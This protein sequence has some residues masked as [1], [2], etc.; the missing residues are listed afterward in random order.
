MAC[1]CGPQGG[2]FENS[3]NYSSPAHGGWGVVKAGHLVPES[4]QLFVSPAACGRHGALAARIEGRK[5]RVS[6]LFLSEEEL[7]SGRYEDAIIEGVA[8]L[9]KHL[10]KLKRKPRALMIFVSCIDDLLGTDHEAILDELYQVHTGVKFIF[11]HMNPTSTDSSVPP[12]VNIQ[13][14]NYTLLD[15]SSTRDNGINIIGNLAPLRANGELKELLHEMNVEAVRHISDYSSFDAYQDMA[16]S[17]LNIVVTPSGK[18]SAENMK[19]KHK[20]PYLMTLTSFRV[21]RVTEMYRNLAEAL[22]EQ[23]PELEAY[24]ARCKA[25]FEETSAYLK[26]MPIIIDGEAIVRPFDLARSLL[27][28]GMNVKYI[29]EQKLLPSDKENFEWLQEHHPE[30]QIMQPQNPKATVAEKY[31]KGALSIGFSAAYI[32]GAQHVLDI[33]GQHGLFGYQGIID[34]LQMMREASQKDADLKKMLDEAVLVV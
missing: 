14:K 9:L 27:E 19:K 4:Y 30:V 26:D 31:G 25:A 1:S 23:C 8:H 33:A 11:C 15:V 24:E 29:Y 5:N 3:L 34:L 16:K 21:E 32:S 7:V 10:E 13:N 2:M 18:Y 28:A 12:A 22:G 17:Q 20:I 6:Y